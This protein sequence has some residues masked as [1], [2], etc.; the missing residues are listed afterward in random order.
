VA[1]PLSETVRAPR[2]L[3]LADGAPVPGAMEAEMTSTSHYAA[4]RFRVRVALGA[5]SD[6]AASWADA[7]DTMLDI[8][9]SLQAGG[10]WV[11]LVQGAVEL[12]R[13]T[14]WRI[15]WCWRGGT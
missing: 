5:A 13:S 2:L 4:D 7:E 12:S 9:M 11:S 8:R 6:A 3:V 15:R 10:P 1:L 14:R